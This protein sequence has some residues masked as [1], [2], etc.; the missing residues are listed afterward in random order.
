[1]TVE[2]IFCYKATYANGCAIFPQEDNMAMLVA[3]ATPIQLGTFGCCWLMLDAVG[4]CW[5]L[6][7]VVGCFWVLL[8]VVGCGWIL[9]GVIGCCWVVGTVGCC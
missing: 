8:D 1:M 6:L 7:G 3:G 2:N 4:W 5:M 9:L